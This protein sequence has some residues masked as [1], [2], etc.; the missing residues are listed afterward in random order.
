[1]SVVYS[2]VGAGIVL[3]ILSP[4]MNKWMDDIH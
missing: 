3:I 1:M 4:F 2:T